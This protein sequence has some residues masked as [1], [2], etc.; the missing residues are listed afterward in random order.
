MNFVDFFKVEVKYS[1][2]FNEITA[3]EWKA[4]ADAVKH[5]G[6]C[7]DHTE[8]HS[9]KSAAALDDSMWIENTYPCNRLASV[10]WAEIREEV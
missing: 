4:K 8:E 7:F 9:D 1:G 6:D 10:T 2:D 5:R 3:E